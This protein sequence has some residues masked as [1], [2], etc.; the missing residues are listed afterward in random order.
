MQL[1]HAND[2]VLPPPKHTATSDEHVA[3]ESESL[4][5]TSNLT[6]TLAPPTQNDGVD[7]R[8]YLRE[9]D[10]AQITEYASHGRVFRIKV[11]PPG[12]LPAYYLEDDDG[13]GTLNKR[14]PGGYKH[15]SPPMWIIKRF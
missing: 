6:E 14:L 5:S 7:V 15:I 1:A 4:E 2:G 3:T 10:K 13:D 11:Q 12:G 9:N 8:T